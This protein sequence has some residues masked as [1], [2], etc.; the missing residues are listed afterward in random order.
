MAR[1]D[2]L[3]QLQARDEKLDMEALQV[4]CH[5]FLFTLTILIHRMHQSP[6]PNPHQSSN[7]RILFN[8]LPAHV[9]THFLD[10]QFRSNMVN[11]RS[12]FR[13]SFSL[14]K[15]DT[16]IHSIFHIAIVF[17]LV[18]HIRRRIQKVLDLIFLTEIHPLCRIGR[19]HTVEYFLLLWR[20]LK[21]AAFLILKHN[22]NLMH[23]E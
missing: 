13:P 7:R 22:D 14:S 3:W 12:S 11:N 4:N 18:S 6:N 1:L 16:P 8:L 15:I 20:I 10:N 5:I 23:L 21:L 9:A 17:R 19:N 2:F